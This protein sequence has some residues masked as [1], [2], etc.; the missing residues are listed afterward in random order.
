MCL[1]DNITMERCYITGM[2]LV[3]MFLKIGVKYPVVVLM[4]GS[5]GRAFKV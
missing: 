2:D 3:L 4:P 1:I 5:V